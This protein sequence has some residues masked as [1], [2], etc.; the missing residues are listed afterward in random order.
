M[1]FLASYMKG[2]RVPLSLDDSDN[3]SRDIVLDLNIC[4]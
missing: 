4:T 1:I 2:D 3:C